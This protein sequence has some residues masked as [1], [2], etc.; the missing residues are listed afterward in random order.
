MSRGKPGA[1]LGLLAAAA[2]A[3]AALTLAGCGAR[4]ES[5]PFAL[6][7]GT[8]IDIR[9][10]PGMPRDQEGRLAPAA[11]DSATPVYRLRRAASVARENE[12][13]AV[14]Y[15]GTLSEARL[16]IFSDRKK[17]LKSV[18]LP[19]AG[20]TRIR[21]LVPL[22]RGDRIWGFQVSA[23]P[24]SSGATS[25]GWLQLAAAGTSP[26]IH[27]FAI[28]GNVLAVDGSVSV[29]AASASSVQARISTATRD[30]MSRGAWQVT[31]RVEPTAWEGDRELRFT[32]LGGEVAVFSVSPPLGVDMLEFSRGT[33]GFLPRDIRATIP[34]RGLE[35]SRLPQGGAIPADPG[36]VL[37]WD[38]ASWRRP[39]F[40]VFSWV[41]LPRVLIFDTA[42]YDVQDALFNR[43][44]F[45]V[46][47]AGY[48]GAIPDPESLSHAY[49]AHDYRAEDLARFFSA[50]E[51]LGIG[52]TPEETELRKI[53]VEE[54]IIRPGDAGY[55]P[56]D[57]AVV[58]ISR[59][60][61]PILRDLLITHECF[62]GVFF[63]IPGF[64]DAC[65]AAWQALS[66][67]EKGVWLAFL[68]SK[69]YNTGD[70]YLVT[71]EF[72]SYLFQQAREEV[73]GFQAVTLSR[74]RSRSAADAGLVSRLRA[75]RPDSFLR[76]FDAL[77]E[78]LRTAGGPPG[79]KA[80]AVRRAR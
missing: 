58:S 8:R 66:D 49:N 14:D 62:H 65:Q 9:E 54:G 22:G 16:T 69:K 61:S 32:G 43:L 4:F 13:F 78:A 38:R 60:S 51:T 11:G 41:R 42:S 56:G 40:E 76:S 57:G 74:L 59:S 37:A 26:F 75:E 73:K 50:A 80:I 48:V 23:G 18:A 53:L 12:A 35:I 70:Q 1:R 28:E 77:D 21:Y 29:L 31:I 10:T 47:K 7:G 27:G 79:G 33:I 19:A 25:G 30:E 55:A 72:Q 45:F 20:A 68:S 24:G 71:N 15:T 17:E 2:L 34:V 46:E 44:A 36:M 63:S 39:D 67:T 5:F 3:A 6:A 52:L 64:R